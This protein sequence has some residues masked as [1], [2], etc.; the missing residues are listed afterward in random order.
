MSAAVELIGGGKSRGT[1]SDDRDLLSCSLF[2]RLRCSPA[3]L[4]GCFDDV[5]FIGA[6]GDRIAVS[7]AGTRLFTQGGTH[8]RGELGKAV[9]HF[10]T[11]VRLLPRAETDKVVPL[12]DQIVQRTARDHAADRQACLTERYAAVHATLA[13]MLAIRFT[14]RGVEL[15]IVFDT[16][17]HGICRIILS[18]IF[19]KSVGISH[20]ALLLISS[21]SA[22]RRLRSWRCPRQDRSACLPRSLR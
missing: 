3:L 4:I 21:G 9:G 2:G 18:F 13:L 12:G 17:F 22:D 10:Q 1:R 14:D 11:V 5:I 15:V 7:A 16:F 19:H 8:A 20:T 6:D